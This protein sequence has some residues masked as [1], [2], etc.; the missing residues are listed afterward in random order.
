MTHHRTGT[1]DEWL[2]ARLELLKVEKELTRL[3]DDLARQRRELPWVRTDKDYLFDTEDGEATL[4]DLF[5][6]RSQLL[7]YH[8]MFDPDWDEGCPS[9]SAVAD[10][11]D[12]THLHLQNHD[13]A[14]TAISRAP[15]EKLLAYRDRMGWS[16]PWASSG[17][18]DFNYDFHV[19]IDPA[20]A[21]VEYN[22]KDQAQLEAENVAWRDWSGEQ[23]GMSAFARDG[24]DVFHTYSA[25]ARGFDALWTMWQWLDR[26]PL[27]RNEGDLS[28]F[29]RHDQYEAGYR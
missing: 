16:F 2:A 26:A 28:W 22:Y 18:S 7:V 29:R 17:R 9:C 3:N 23:P 24:D 12:E 13:V 27:G 4:A 6:G 14:F 21:P 20:V 8:F 19:T 25:Y 1:R 11:F 10:G 5:R 15:L